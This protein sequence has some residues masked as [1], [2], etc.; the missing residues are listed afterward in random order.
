VR[1]R[2][3]LP[4]GAQAFVRAWVCQARGRRILTQ[5]VMEDAAGATLAEARAL[6]L[7]LPGGGG[8]AGTPSGT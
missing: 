4:L 7:R 6:F 3:P 2:R 1:Y 8:A 5:A